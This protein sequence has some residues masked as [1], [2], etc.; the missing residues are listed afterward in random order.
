MAAEVG[1]GVVGDEQRVAVDRVWWQPAELVA[2]ET[3]RAT[4]PQQLGDQANRLRPLAGRRSELKVD[5]HDFPERKRIEH[6]S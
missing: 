5:Q 4:R 3:D 6:S 1:A 2:P